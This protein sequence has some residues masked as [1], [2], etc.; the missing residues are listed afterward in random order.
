[1]EVKGKILKVMEVVTGQGKKG[2]WH[3]QEFILEQPGQYPKPVS[4]SL[5]GEKKITDYDLEAGLEITAHIELESRENN[6]RW[7]TEVRA[8]KITWTEQGGR[9]WLPNN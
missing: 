2:P 8:W 9:R 4:I 3:R 5:W 1:M 6:G 7:Y